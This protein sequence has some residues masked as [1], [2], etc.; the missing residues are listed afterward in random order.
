[1][2]FKR[3]WPLILLAC[4]GVA[5]ATQG[6]LFSIRGKFNTT[7]KTL[8]VLRLT[9]TASPDLI[10]YN[11]DLVLSNSGTTPTTSDGGHGGLVVNLLSGAAATVSQG[12]VIISSVGLSGGFATTTTANDTKVIGVADESIATGAVGRVKVSGLAVVLTTHTVAVGDILVSTSPAGRAATDN[13]P[14][15]GAGLGKALTAGA[16]AGDTVLI[17]LGSH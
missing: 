14:T 15:D 1:M 2:K 4:V 17:L 16:A 12:T 13:T 10:V 7:L 6:D 9:N 5:W 11:G 3:F 8:S